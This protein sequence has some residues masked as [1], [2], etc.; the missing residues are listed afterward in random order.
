MPLAHDD[1]SKITLDRDNARICKTEYFDT[2][3]AIVRLVPI[4]IDVQED[5]WRREAGRSEEVQGL[6]TKTAGCFC[7]NSRSVLTQLT[8]GRPVSSPPV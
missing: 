1:L 5:A 4:A 3:N 8:R 2:T 7:V 6:W